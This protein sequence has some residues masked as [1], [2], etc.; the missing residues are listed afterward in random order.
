MIEQNILEAMVSLKKYNG[1]PVQSRQKIVAELKRGGN[2]Y[3][4]KNISDALAS[5]VRKGN[6]EK[7]KASYR[8]IVREV[9]PLS[10]LTRGIDPKSLEEEEGYAYIISEIL[11]LPNDNVLDNTGNRAVFSSLGKAFDYFLSTT[12]GKIADERDEEHF[13]ATR[14]A[15]FS[16]RA[17]VP[18]ISHNYIYLL[19][20]RFFD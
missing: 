4:T 17:K 12:Q 1:L 2:F 16:S 19:R 5:L 11:Y 14:G 15:M 7:V 18:T 6:L 10:P 9:K 3:P 20:V 8:L 13:Y